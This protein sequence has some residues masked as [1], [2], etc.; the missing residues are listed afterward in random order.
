MDHEGTSVRAQSEDIPCLALH[1]LGGG[2]YELEPLIAALKTIGVRVA[3]PILV[4][5]EGP[6]PLMPASRWQ[7]WANSAEAAFDELAGSGNPVVVVGFS[8]GATLA[9]YLA[10]RRPVARLVL[11]APFL[12]IRYSGLIPVPPATYLRTLA[13][14][15]P[16]LPRRAPAVRDRQMRRFAAGTDRFRTFSVHA[17]ISALELI[18]AVKPLVPTIT[19][20]VLILQGRRDSVVEPAGATWLYDHIGSIEKAPRRAASLRPPGLARLRARPGYRIIMRVCGWSGRGD[21]TTCVSVRPQRSA[22]SLTSTVDLLP[23]SRVDD[24]KLERWAALAARPRRVPWDE[25][26][27]CHW[28]RRRRRRAR[29]PAKAA[30]L[31]GST[32]VTLAAGSTS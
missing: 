32:S 11:L 8:T 13:R 7:D 19:T 31:P 27:A 24:H 12:A 2:P 16:N 3:A 23:R 15:I 17:A 4:G 20:P 28:P 22:P 21:S 1:G 29:V 25:G 14:V 9:L 30:G 26:S 6:G 5:H 18:E 10:A